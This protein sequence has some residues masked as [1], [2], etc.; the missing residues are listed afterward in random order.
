M[1]TSTVR[2][3]GS[4]TNPNLFANSAAYIDALAGANLNTE[5][6]KDRNLDNDP[7]PDLY[8]SRPSD[9]FRH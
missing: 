1:P 7:Y 8:D 3:V 6:Y 5:W 9:P 4:I 2:P